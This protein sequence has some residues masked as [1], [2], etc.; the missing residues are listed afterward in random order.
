MPAVTFRVPKH[1]TDSLFI[2]NVFGWFP[3]FLSSRICF[4]FMLLNCR[5]DQIIITQGVHWIECPCHLPWLGNYKNALL[6]L[7]RK[8]EQ[9]GFFQYICLFCF[10]AIQNCLFGILPP[11]N[12]TSILSGEMLKHYL[13]LESKQWSQHQCKEPSCWNKWLPAL[14]G[15]PPPRLVWHLSWCGSASNKLWNAQLLVYASATW[16][17]QNLQWALKAQGYT[18]ILITSC[19]S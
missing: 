6:Y 16:I 8:F 13:K 7:L 5:R 14:W 4:I 2:G 1:C 17:W 18:R 19:K 9:A 11:E 15:T 3:L 10:R 12:R